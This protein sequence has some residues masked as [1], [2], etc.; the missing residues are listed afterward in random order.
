M[1]EG[2]V[3]SRRRHRSGLVFGIGLLVLGGLLLAMNLGYAVPWSWWRYV[4]IA[5]MAL[6]A[7]GLILPN[8]HMSRSGGIW[9]LA[10][11]L[12]LLIG[13]NDLWNLGWAGAWPI[14]VIA[15]GLAVIL[16]R[17]EYVHDDGRAPER[18]DGES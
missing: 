12:Y 4:P 6:G 18:S 7:W 16:R 15:G 11:G 3:Q 10:S 13:I 17:H 9:M 8:R 5:L 14:F 1:N 2:S